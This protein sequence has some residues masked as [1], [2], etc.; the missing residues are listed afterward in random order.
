MRRQ[1]ILNAI[2]NL[3]YYKKF[4]NPKGLPLT[5]DTYLG[6]KCERY[7]NLKATQ[8]HKDNPHW[9]P[10]I[11][12][13]VGSPLIAL[14]ITNDPEY[15]MVPTCIFEKDTPKESIKPDY[16]HIKDFIGLDPSRIDA[17]LLEILMQLQ[18]EIIHDIENHT[19]IYIF[20][21]QGILLPRSIG[22]MHFTL[23]STLT[24]NHMILQWNRDTKKPGNPMHW[25]NPYYLPNTKPSNITCSISPNNYNQRE[26]NSPP[27]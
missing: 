9:L 4:N 3:A 13:H 10:K 8:T 7:I 18:N 27:I 21:F 12:Q 16:L 25:Q 15:G 5:K 2:E 24:R 26:G 1:E 6:I 19:H 23:T 14:G 22:N 20:E 17:L 11:H